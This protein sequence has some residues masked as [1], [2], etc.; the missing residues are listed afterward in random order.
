MFS[1]GDFNGDGLPDV[2]AR[3]P[4]G[5]LVLY[6]G[7]GAG[8]L[9]NHGVTVGTGGFDVYNLMFSPGDFNGDGLPDVLARK[10]SGEL[11]RYLGNGNGGL[12]NHGVTIGK[13]WDPFS[14][15]F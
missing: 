7:N 8:G 3:K 4:S 12:A 11:V 15:I 6:S 14:I 13:D 9:A 10:P 1:P 2:L 5:E